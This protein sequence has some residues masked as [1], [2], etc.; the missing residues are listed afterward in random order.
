M[1]TQSLFFIGTMCLIMSFTSYAGDWTGHWQCQT[2]D[3][4][5]EIEEFDR[6]IR[7]RQNN[8]NWIDARRSGYNRY[9]DQRGDEYRLLNQH[10]LEYLTQG[11]AYIMY[12]GNYNRTD[13]RRDYRKDR[14]WYSKDRRYSDKFN[15]DGQW[16][17]PS[18]GMKIHIDERRNHIKVR[19]NRGSKETFHYQHRGIY[20]DR[21]GNQLII[22]RS[23]I[24]EY[25][26]YE[27]DLFMRFYQ[28]KHHGHSKSHF[29]W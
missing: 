23:G 5:F 16:I 2:H 1:K 13:D 22:K 12:R 10:K 25:T 14:D 8:R 18:T 6:G 27:G 29:R 7:I 20:R 15:V 17:N 3:L 4:V 19:F 11:K 9:R 28:G 24:I 21:H 26:S